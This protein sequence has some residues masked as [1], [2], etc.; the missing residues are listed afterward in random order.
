MTLLSLVA[1]RARNGVIG[2]NGHLPWR[3][4]EDLAFFKR[5]TLGSPV[6][7][8]R[9]T[10]ESIGHPLPGRHNFVVTH[11]GTR[12]FPDCETVTSLEAALKRCNEEDVAEAFLIGGAQLYA[13]GLPRA[14]KLILTEIDRDFEGD[15]WFPEI[16]LTQWRECSRECHRSLPP[17]DFRYAFVIHQR[18]TS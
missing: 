7:M 10:Y 6:I 17:N 14:D 4:P 18:K 12:V 2:C 1:A 5:T 15:T 13:L 8:G 3:L 9:K 11:D 16:D